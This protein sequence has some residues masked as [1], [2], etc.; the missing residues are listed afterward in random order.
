MIDNCEEI[1]KYLL[2]YDININNYR[3][4]YV[5]LESNNY[6]KLGKLLYTFNQKLIS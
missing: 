5:K 1:T 4:E 6:G 2:E 3:I